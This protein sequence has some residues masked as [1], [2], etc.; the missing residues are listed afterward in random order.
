VFLSVPGLETEGN[1]LTG[2]VLWSDHFGNLITNI[3]E[4]DLS[5]QFPEGISRILAGEEILFGLRKNYAQEPPGHLL[6]L[7]GSSGYL[8][9]ACTLGSAAKKLGYEPGKDLPVR[10]MGK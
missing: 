6:A 1:T 9:I 10:V 4:K 8:E 3:H 2:R 5:G 7:I